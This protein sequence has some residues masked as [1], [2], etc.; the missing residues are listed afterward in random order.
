[1]TFSVRLATLVCLFA[2]TTLGNAPAASAQEPKAEGASGQKHVNVFNLVEGRTTILTAMSEG[3]RVMKGDLIC[4]LDSSDVKER[5]A[6]HELVTR[7]AQ[8]AARGA[9]M[10]QEA[11]EL[12][13]TEYIEAGYK[14]ESNAIKREIAGS[15]AA[16]SRA[17]VR[18]ETLQRRPAREAG[19]DPEVLTA[20]FELDGDIF[21]YELAK[22]KKV[23][24]E[25]YT[26]DRTIK[27]LK[28]KIEMARAEELARSA[29]FER[30]KAKGKTLKMQ[31]EKCK[32]IAPANGR[33]SYASPIE[34]GVPVHDGQLLFRI[35]TVDETGAD[36]K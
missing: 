20:K 34:P 33:L 10:A 29:A 6:H 28:G 19:I 4:E 27:S 35:I 15:E 17:E 36:A 16:R 22:D 25:K 12:A 5:I 32:I 21:A 31:V 2:L 24:L 3:T 1:M 26:R 7:A 18:L 9:R 23:R 8:L 30:A 13:L 11:A 14:V